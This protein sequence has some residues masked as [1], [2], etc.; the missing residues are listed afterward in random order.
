VSTHVSQAGVHS[1]S[2]CRLLPALSLALR[3]PLTSPIQHL[4]G[5]GTDCTLLLELVLYT[6]STLMTLVN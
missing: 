5:V 6:L 4:D 3:G 2:C 1:A